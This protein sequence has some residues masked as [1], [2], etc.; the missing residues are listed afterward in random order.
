MPVR[1]NENERETFLAGVHIGVLSVGNG[2]GRPPLTAPTWY[3]Y[4]P[5]GDVTFFTNTQGHK[6][7]KTQLIE[8]AG[9][10]SL[11]VQQESHPYRYVTVEGRVIKADRPP[12]EENMLAVVR[13]Y[14]PEESA[15]GFVQSELEHPD[16]QLVLFTVRPDRWLAQDFRE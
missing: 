13:R 15:Q 6:A 5:G 2:T 14:L 16:S 11:C 4:Q 3:G 12:S 1:M 7:R 9:A 10:V 8:A